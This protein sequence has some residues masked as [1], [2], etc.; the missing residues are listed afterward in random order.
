LLLEYQHVSDRHRQMAMTYTALAWHSTGKTTVRT[1]HL[2]TDSEPQP[3][4]CR[5]N[6]CRSI[7]VDRHWSNRTE[8][9]ISICRIVV[10]IEL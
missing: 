2:A 6:R 5:L 4:H 10:N 3:V 8:P 9:V 7:F 1:D